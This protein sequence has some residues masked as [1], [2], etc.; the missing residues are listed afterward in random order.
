VSVRAIVA[1]TPSRVIGQGGKVPWHYP[2]DMHWFKR[3]TMGHAVLMGRKTFESIGKPLPG[4]LNLVVSRTASFQGVEM[5][6][7]LVGFQLERFDRDVYVIGGAEV[8]RTLLP[9]T[10]E[11]LVTHV[12]KECS[13]DTYFP[14]YEGAFES[15]EELLQTPDF[16]IK[17][18]VR[19]NPEHVL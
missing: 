16:V 10:K 9:I 3:T 17:R 8:Y 7:D 14:E 4:R 6:R 19:R 13:G 2:E 12:L 11:L 18:H 5:I 15:A 1:M